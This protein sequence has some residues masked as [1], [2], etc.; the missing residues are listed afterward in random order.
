[1]TGQGT[2]QNPY[3]PTIWA[4]FKTAVETSEAY[5]KMPDDTVWN[6][7]TWFPTDTTGVTLNCTEIDGNNAIIKNLRKTSGELFALDNYAGH[8]VSIKNLKFQNCYFSEARMFEAVGYSYV[9]IKLYN[10]EVDGEFV[11]GSLWG[12][13]SQGI[14][15][16]GC[17]ISTHLVNSTISNNDKKIVDTVVNINGEVSANI[18]TLSL[19]NSAVYGDVGCGETSRAFN[20][21]GESCVVDITLD[22]FSSVNYWDSATT[23]LVNISKIGEATTYGDFIQATTSQMGDA[24]WLEEHGFPVETGGE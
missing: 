17:S 24:E 12:S 1:M 23:A 22:N 16:H 15:C 21:A 18:G 6:M 8:N 4:E 13:D 2:Q 19:I 10:V 11:S 5:V 9:A 3:I 7:L 14:E 20:F